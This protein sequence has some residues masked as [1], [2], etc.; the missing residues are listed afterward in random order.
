MH[1]DAGCNYTTCGM[2]EFEF[3]SVR[4]APPSVRRPSSP[5]LIKCV[6]IRCRIHGFARA[7]HAFS[8]GETCLEDVDGGRASRHRLAGRILGRPRRSDA[9]INIVNVVNVVIMA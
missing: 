7:T 9:R 4:T 6:D 3:F 8:R 2:S 1:P 5:Q